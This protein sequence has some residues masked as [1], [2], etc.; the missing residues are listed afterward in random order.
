MDIYC[1]D[2]GEFIGVGNV[3]LY[4][5]LCPAC[6]SAIQ[7]KRSQ[8]PMATHYPLKERFSF[9]DFVGGEFAISDGKSIVRLSLDGDGERIAHL[10]SSHLE[11][12]AREESTR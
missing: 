9:I 12:E 7:P 11:D 6:F 4:G 5:D 8:P 3:R 1:H 2:C 10:I